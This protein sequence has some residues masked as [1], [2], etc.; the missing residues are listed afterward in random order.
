[1]CSIHSYIAQEGS[2]DPPSKEQ[3]K[4]MPCQALVT[5]RCLSKGIIA[6][7]DKDRDLP[8]ATEA[9]LSKATNVLITPEEYPK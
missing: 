3:L 9:L 5:S 7:T 1:M 8:S 2:E 4:K 6:G